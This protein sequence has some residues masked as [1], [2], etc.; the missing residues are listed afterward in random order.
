[1]TLQ[2][3]AVHKW[4]AR[5]YWDNDRTSMIAAVTTLYSY[6]TAIA[7]RAEG[8]DT[9]YVNTT[10]YTNTT[11]KHQSTLRHVLRTHAPDARIIYVH[12][13]PWRVRGEDL[14]HEADRINP[15]KW[16]QLNTLLLDNH[17]RSEDELGHTLVRHTDPSLI[18]GSHE[19]C[20]RCGHYMHITP[21]YVSSYDDRRKSLHFEVSGGAVR[22]KCSRRLEIASVNAAQGE[23][24][25][26]YA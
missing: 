1:M 22:Y 18:N 4:L 21:R 12:M 11:A 13:L 26:E 20:P 5:E 23:P 10:H 2:E 6:A 19:Y 9:I 15:I 25:V 16:S 3:R 7:Y 14:Q 17:R 24:Y 8:D